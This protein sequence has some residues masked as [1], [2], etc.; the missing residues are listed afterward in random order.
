MGRS[1]P[2]ET[3]VEWLDGGEKPKHV[4]VDRVSRR[5][6][7][8]PLALAV[9]IGV[10]A[11]L[12]VLIGGA[13]DSTAIPTADD[14]ALR[15]RAEA[16]DDISL[17]LLPDA[18]NDVNAMQG[19]VVNEI[20]GLA[21]LD[22]ALRAVLTTADGTE[23]RLI[24]VSTTGDVL[25]APLPRS[26]EFRFDSSGKW[27]AGISLTE[28][29]GQRQVL[30]A[31]RVGSEPE[32]VAVGIRSYAWHNATGGLLAWSDADGTGVTTLALDDETD[33]LNTI[34]LPITGLLEGWGHWGFALLTSGASFT[35]AVVDPDGAVLGT[36]LPGRFS[37]YL[38]NGELLLTGGSGEPIAF[39]PRSG[40]QRSLSWLDERDYVWTS[41]VSAGRAEAVVLV[42]R[43]GIE[44]DPFR[45]EIALITDETAQILAET[46]AFTDL[47]WT[48]DYQS[49]V[50]ADQQTSDSGSHGRIRVIGQDGGVDTVLIPDLFLG[51]EWVAALSVN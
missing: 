29:G 21:D 31:G 44:A 43:E 16:L 23:A 3:D 9:G 15:R 50:F 28:Q 11:T 39:D 14:E 10:L 42:G 40:R 30:W 20:R 49:I 48:P 45:G 12:L 34:D 37:G 13:D 5:R 24:S 25:V 35:T 26:S 17:S 2:A 6:S 51:R 38:A 22:L 32:P 1:S 4:S 7:W 46:A 33:S 41:S 36:S 18:E 27:L 47:A 19:Q 8:I